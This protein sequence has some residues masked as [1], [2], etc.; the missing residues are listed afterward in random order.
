MQIIPKALME[1]PDSPSIN[2][3][4]ANIYGKMERFS[5]AEQHFLKAIK[6]FGIRV[7]AIH[8]A[9]L[10]TVVFKNVG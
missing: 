7:Q 9:N 8:Y 2:F 1:L 3:A 5:E 6:L 4:V 10:G